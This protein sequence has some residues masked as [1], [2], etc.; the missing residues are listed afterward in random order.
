MDSTCRLGLAIDSVEKELVPAPD[1][2]AA[3]LC[4]GRGTPCPSDRCSMWS[5]RPD[6]RTR[7]P[8]RSRGSRDVDLRRWSEPRSCPPRAMSAGLMFRDNVV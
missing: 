4:G 6:R 2:G 1:N 3:S 7:W 5:I 8:F